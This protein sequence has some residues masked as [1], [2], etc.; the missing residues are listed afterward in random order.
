MSSR[1]LRKLQGL[2]ETEQLMKAMGVDAR[3][4]ERERETPSRKKLIGFAAL[5]DEVDDEQ[6]D[7]DELDTEIT[8]SK[9][10]S[11]KKKRKKKKKRAAQTAKDESFDDILEK[12]GFK[13]EH[14]NENESVSEMEVWKTSLKVEAKYL[15][16]DAE[17][18]R[19]FGSAAVNSDRPNRRNQ[20]RVSRGGVLVNANNV[21]HIPGGHGGLG[22][23]EDEKRKKINSDLSWWR[24]AH[25]RDYQQVQADFIATIKNHNHEGLMKIIQRHPCHIDT[26]LALS[27]A[28]RL[29]DDSTACKEL[30]ERLL[31]VMESSLHPRCVIASGKNRFDYNRPENRPLF[32]ALFRYA[33]LSARRGCWRTA[34]EQAKLLL[35][36]DP[37][38]DPLAAV[39][40]LPVFAVRAGRFEE[41]LQMES[42]LSHRNVSDLPNWS[43]SLAL[44]NIQLSRDE[45]A[46]GR[47]ETC[48]QKFPGLLMP[49]LEAMQAEPCHEIKISPFFNVKEDAGKKVLYDIICKR[50]IELW[51]ETKAQGYLQKAAES[52][53]K[54]KL[55]PIVPSGAGKIPPQIAR[56]AILSDI[57]IANLKPEQSFLFDPIPPSEPVLEYTPKAPDASSQI[58]GFGSLHELFIQSMFPG[59]EN[60]LGENN[61]Q[62]QN[63]LDSMSNLLEQ[64]RTVPGVPESTEH[65]E[66]DEFD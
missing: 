47:L 7:E 51:K 57:P 4:T 45:E 26:L 8:P 27:D 63:L 30:L 54:R 19:I 50:E 65:L 1:Q 55:N 48:L 49:L 39:L 20:H 24:F 33:S 11:S 44:A 13:N 2:N 37:Q 12:Y 17:L 56:H 53:L 35:S 25:N 18:R 42:E 23:F 32:G 14:Q 66:D 29:Q 6:D 36:F 15:D 10:N 59:Y 58:S 16:P 22:C 3:E 60:R 43:L 64:L 62:I 21:G 34:F 9:T 40:L 61:L 38:S 41:L 46:M 28:C 31:H 5:A 52:I